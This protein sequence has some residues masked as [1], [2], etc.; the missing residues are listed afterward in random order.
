V[1]KGRTVKVGKRREE[2][3]RLGK[4]GRI[5]GGKVGRA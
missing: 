3:L 1:G 5:K 2:V 4:R